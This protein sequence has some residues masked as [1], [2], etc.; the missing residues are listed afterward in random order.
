MIGFIRRDDVLAVVGNCNN[1]IKRSHQSLQV[2]NSGRDGK[3]G[4]YLGRAVE[5]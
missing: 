4:R 1:D 5:W 2:V 3:L